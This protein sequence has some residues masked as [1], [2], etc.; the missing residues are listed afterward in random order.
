MFTGFFNAGPVSA[1][2]QVEQ[3]NQHTPLSGIC[4]TKLD[5]SAKGGIVVPLTQMHS[6]PIPFVGLGE[7]I[8]DI[9]PFRVHEYADSLFASNQ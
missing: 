7:K 4:L 1:L 2:S 9:A 3:F 8:E 5:G 6:L